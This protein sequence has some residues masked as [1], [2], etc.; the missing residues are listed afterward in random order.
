MLCSGM[1]DFRVVGPRSLPQ[2]VNIAAGNSSLLIFTRLADDALSSRTL[3]A[4]KRLP[5]VR[6]AAS[7]HTHTALTQGGEVMPGATEVQGLGW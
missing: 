2:S 3:T 5:H 7:T 4:D 1:L 6:K